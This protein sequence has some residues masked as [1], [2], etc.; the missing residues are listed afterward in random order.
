MEVTDDRDTCCRLRLIPSE[1]SYKRDQCSA[2]RGKSFG[3]ECETFFNPGV[4]KA[5]IRNSGTVG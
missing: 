4:L 1:R 3:I 2:S 5:R